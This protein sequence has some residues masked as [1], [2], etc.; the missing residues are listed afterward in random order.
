MEEILL[1][2][3]DKEAP[4]NWL[5]NKSLIARNGPPPD[6]LLAK[7]APK[8]PKIVQAIA[9][10]GSCTLELNGKPWLLKTSL[11]LNT[12]QRE[13]KPELGRKASSCFPGFAVPGARLAARR[14]L[15]ST[16]L[17]SYGPCVQ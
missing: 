1:F 12:R 10:T 6:K 3:G 11:A 7:E 13:T 17:P 15:S 16:V 14:E 8:T 2:W 4:T 9:T 5:L